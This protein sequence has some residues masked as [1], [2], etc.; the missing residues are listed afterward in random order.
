MARLLICN[1]EDLSVA[2]NDKLQFWIKETSVPADET[3][4]LGAIDT[5]ENEATENIRL[6]YSLYNLEPE[7]EALDPKVKRDLLYARAFRD[8]W[9]LDGVY[10]ITENGDDS[11]I[12]EF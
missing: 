5:V 1:V 4:C 2:L 11:S 7:L 6:C 9:C 3:V 10:I 12:E 8:K